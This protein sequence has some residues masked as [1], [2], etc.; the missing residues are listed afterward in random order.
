MKANDELYC[1]DLDWWLTQR[2]VECGWRTNFGGFVAMLERGGGGSGS[3]DSSDPYHELY[4]SRLESFE[5][6]RRLA[7]EWNQL[8][9][10]DRRV[11][12]AHY[13]APLLA[14]WCKGIGGELGKLAGTAALV[15]FDADELGPFL[16]ACSN[17]SAKGAGERIA[18]VRDKAE[19]H[20][21][22]A[23]RAYYQITEAALDAWVA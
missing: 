13:A 14:G 16:D 2:D 4:V 21:R 3:V 15:A 12:R 11:L 1:A 20:T 6:D 23:H 8:H 19:E 5:R 7:K 9:V 22:R 10:L 18:A 17:S